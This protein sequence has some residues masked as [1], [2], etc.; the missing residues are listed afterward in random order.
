[1]NSEIQIPFPKWNGMHHYQIFS[2]GSEGSGWSA[3]NLIDRRFLQSPI[4]F[5]FGSFPDG[6]EIN[7]TNLGEVCIRRIRSAHS[8]TDHTTNNHAPPPLYLYRRNSYII[9]EKNKFRQSLVHQLLPFPVSAAFLLL[10][11]VFSSSSPGNIYRTERRSGS[12]SSSHFGSRFHRHVEQALSSNCL[13]KS[14]W[15]G[16][17]A[18]RGVGNQRWSRTGRLCVCSRGARATT[19]LCPSLP[20]RTRR[21]RFGMQGCLNLRRISNETTLTGQRRMRTLSLFL[22]L[23]GAAVFVDCAFEYLLLH[24]CQIFDD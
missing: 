7:P 14:R 11:A 23:S 17:A 22:L 4:K 8:C 5:V 12:D 15:L 1:M 16:P 2:T 21:G 24:A 6:R 19:R 3:L 20:E 9:Q 10:W 18:M 13:S